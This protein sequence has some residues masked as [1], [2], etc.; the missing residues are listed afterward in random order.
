ML[1]VFPHFFS[2]FLF[3]DYYRGRP[4]L[5]MLLEMNPF[6]SCNVE[7]SVTVNVKVCRGGMEVSV[8]PEPQ[9][10]KNQ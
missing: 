9:E 6:W 2:I 10:N 5:V 4:L 8:D 7:E 1:N 3:D